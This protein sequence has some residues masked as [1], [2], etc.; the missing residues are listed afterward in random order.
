[1]I[2]DVVIHADEI[3]AY[4]E[5]MWSGRLPIRVQLMI[6]V[7]Q[8][9]FDQSALLDLGF[10]TGFGNELVRIGGAKVSVDG[11]F[12]QAVFRPLEDDRSRLHP[13]QRMAPDELNEV[14]NAYHRAGSR[15]CIH[16]SGDAALELALAS[17]E[18]VLHDRP[19]DDHRHRIEHMGNWAM[20]PDHLARAQRIG[21][22]P[23]PNA[24]ELVYMAGAARD[25]F[26]ERRLV[27]PFAFRSI[28]EA[29]LPLVLASDGGGLW[30]VDPLRDVA[31]A[32]DDRGGTGLGEETV[33]REVAFAAV[34]RNPAW[35]GF[36][37]HVSG[38]LGTGL[39]ADLAILD[40]DPLTASLS[41]KAPIGIVGTLMGGRVT[42]SAHPRLAVEDARPEAPGWR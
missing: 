21:A 38:M 15:V 34:T 39:R 32:S 23:V 40:A 24:S 14:V 16:A 2:H 3:R 42:H 7:F 41:S 10:G 27:N 26:D 17:L 31:A 9:A 29:G 13:V 30:P 4:Q 18:R 1:M 37:E 19:R 6:R 11:G 33:D 35:L 12:D 28:V 5:L 8:S 25:T 36:E 20:T 22:V